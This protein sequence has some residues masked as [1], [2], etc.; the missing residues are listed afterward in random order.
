MRDL[1]GFRDRHDRSAWKK[2]YFLR[3]PNVELREKSTTNNTNLTNK[4][5][6]LGYRVIVRTYDHDELVA[7]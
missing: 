4:D 7:R 6:K 2:R 5:G 1:P 3:N